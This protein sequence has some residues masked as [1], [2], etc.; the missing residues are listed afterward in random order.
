MAAPTDAEVVAQ[1]RQRFGTAEPDP[2]LGPIEGFLQSGV[3]SS[4]EFFGASPFPGVTKYRTEYPIA[5]M[6]SEMIGLGGTYGVAYGASKKIQRLDNLVERIKKGTPN[7]IVGGAAASAAR[8]APL[9]ALAATSRVTLGDQD[10]GES[11]M[12]A[13][14]NSGIN[15]TVGAIGGL[16][17]SAGKRAVRNQVAQLVDLRQNKTVQLRQTKDAI[18]NAEGI[19]EE[20]L[21]KLREQAQ[22]LQR[23]IFAEAAPETLTKMY[24]GTKG[25][26]QEKIFDGAG[27]IIDLK[28]QKLKFTNGIFS[29]TPV[30][31]AGSAITRRRNLT[32]GPSGFGDDSAARTRAFADFR[33]DDEFA[34]VARYPRMISFNESKVS[35][36]R[37]EAMATEFRDEIVQNW[38]YL[39]GNGNRQFYGIQ[40]AEGSELIVAERLAGDKI[41]NDRWLTY[42]TDSIGIQRRLPNQANWA[43]RVANFSMRL[44]QSLNKKIDFATVDTPGMGAN[45]RQAG[46]DILQTDS[47]VNRTVELIDDVAILE[48]SGVNN[49]SSARKL[50]EKLGISDSEAIG[51]LGEFFKRY[52]SPL[53]FQFNNSALARQIIATAKFAEDMGQLRATTVLGGTATLRKGNILNSILKGPGESKRGGLEPLIRSFDDEDLEQLW[54]LDTSKADH[55]L[56]VQWLKRQIANAQPGSYLEEIGPLRPK[57]EKYLEEQFKADAANILEISALAKLTDTTV[58]RFSMNHIGLTRGFSGDYRAAIRDTDAGRVV[59]VLAGKSMTEVQE[60]AAE[61]IEEA[62]K[63]DKAWALDQAGP[64]NARHEDYNKLFQVT[65]SDIVFGNQLRREIGFRARRPGQLSRAS[66]KLDREL[67]PGVE[68][69]WTKEELIKGV[70][71]HHRSIGRYIAEQT[72][73]LHG[74][75]M[76]TELYKLSPQYLD[77]VTQRVDDVFL[78]AGRITK[79]INNF[80]DQALAPALGVNSASKIVQVAN[81]MMFHWMLG[82]GNAG[83]VAVNALTFMQTTLPQA[84]FVLTAPIERVAKYYS[85][86]PIFDKNGLFRTQMS[87]LDPV[88]VIREG[89][90]HIRKPEPEFRGFV[91]RAAVEGVWDPRFVEQWVGK[92]ASAITD[93][94][95]AFETPGGFAKWLTELSSFGPSVTERGTRLHSFATGYNIGKEFLRLEGDALYR[96]SKEFTNNSMFLYSQADRARI[97]TGPLGSALGLFKNWQMHQMHWLAQFMGEGL[98][99]NAAPMMWQMMGTAAVGGAIATPGFVLADA[100]SRWLTDESLL[101]NVYDTMASPDG[102]TGLADAVMFGLPATLGLSMQGAATAPFANPVRDATALTNFVYVDRGKAVSAAA[103]TALDTYFATG[104]HPAESRDATLQMMK[105]LAPKT[106]YRAYD[107]MSDRAISS[108]RTGNPLIKDLGVGEGFMYSVGL[109]PTQVE[110]KFAVANELWNDQQSRRAA[111]QRF[112]EAIAQAQGARDYKEATNLLLQSRWAGLDPTAV[113]RSAQSRLYRFNQD[114]IDRQFDPHQVYK[115]RN[116][117]VTGGF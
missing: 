1:M 50:A 36:P 103:G 80:A 86:V 108:W 12:Q 2:R 93:M 57:V 4:L 88:R 47:I 109:T 101:Q 46:M 19:N 10:I 73:Q 37:K 59:Y 58:P 6:L 31:S 77:Q 54:R 78:R 81:G 27:G 97:I 65:D 11:M 82:L 117:G 25:K 30:K 70:T 13:L 28:D 115:Y 56:D 92:N 23:E 5:G 91:E 66:G 43:D 74:S 49:A 29:T 15:A 116:T 14:I 69:P 18:R 26:G 38:K 113:L 60:R 33:V 96:F 24:Q 99:G 62:A 87:F 22:N 94:K 40:S 102:S 53:P 55:G 98:R 61:L 21:T 105:A 52:F 45:P 85:S 42:M 89:W 111:T 32:R 114:Q 3:S 51:R 68:R 107:V 64:I 76:M 110:K 95:S 8:F 41:Q 16:I 44:G 72:F 112:G 7:Q 75:P 48:T 35:A 100:A 63:K 20:T 84:A 83:F 9:E 104:K 34:E 106:F 39:G 79:T 90:K 67:T 17:T 71:E